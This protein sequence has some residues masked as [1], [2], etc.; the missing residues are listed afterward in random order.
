MACYVVPTLI[1]TVFP[2][3][4]DFLGSLQTNMSGFFSGEKPISDTL[5]QSSVFW[6]SRGGSPVSGGCDWRGD[7]PDYC[8]HTWR[9]SFADRP[10]RRSTKIAIAAPGTGLS[11]FADQG[12][13]RTKSPSVSL[14]LH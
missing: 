5:S 9:F 4:R 2:L 1:F 13:R 7:V 12:D 6:G 8:G 3:A 14:A 10:V 11:I